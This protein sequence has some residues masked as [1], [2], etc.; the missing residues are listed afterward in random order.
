MISFVVESFKPKTKINLQQNKGTSLTSSWGPNMWSLLKSD[1]RHGHRK[2]PYRH[3][4]VNC[5][6]L[7]D[8]ATPWIIAF[9][10]PL[11]MEF[12]RQEYWSGLPFPSPGD[13][14]IPGFKPRSLALHADPL[15]SKTPGKSHVKFKVV[16]SMSLRSSGKLMETHVSISWIE[17]WVV[18]CSFM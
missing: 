5:S 4:S 6:I 10:A 14:P 18:L 16:A 2:K 1:A 12:C 8:S 17:T 7:S 9:Q 13:L 11:S 3:S 15:L